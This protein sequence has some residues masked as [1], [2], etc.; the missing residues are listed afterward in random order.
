[1]RFSICLL[2]VAVSLG[3]ALECDA[4]A[5]EGERVEVYPI[6]VTLSSRRARTQFVVTGID[7]GGQMR[8]LTREAQFSVKD[9]QVATVRSA[10]AS[11]VHDGRTGIVVKVGEREVVVP[12][13]V[14]G[15]EKPDPVRFQAETLAVL[16]KQGCNA[17]SCHGSPEGKGGFSLSLFA[18][19]PQIDE[20]SLVRGGRNRRTLVVEPAESLLLRKPMLRVAHRGGKKLSKTDAAYGILLDWIAEGTHPDP[21]DAPKCTGVV[22]HPGPARILHLPDRTQQQLSVSAQFSD[23]SSR[24]VTAIATYD[25]SDREVLAV[26]ANGLAT[27]LKRGQSA[28]SVRYQHCLVSVHFTVIQDV[29]GFH[30][31]EPPQNNF[32]DKL[33]DDRLRLLQYT[34][35][36]T[37]DDGVFLRRVSLDLTG[38]LPTAAEAKS[39]LADGAV[40]KRAKLIDRLLDS[41]AHA[42]FW[43]HRTADLLR[44][45]PHT[46]KDGRAEKF[47]AWIVEAYEKNTPA[48]RFAADLLTAVGDGRTAAPANYYLGAPDRN[49]LAETTAQL[50]L[51]SRIGCAKCHNHPFENWTQ[52]DYF[53][54]GAVFARVRHENDVVKLAADGEVYHPTSGAKL[55][56]WGLDEKQSEPADRRAA[57]AAWLTQ[58]GNPFFAR[59]EANR[60]W[61]YLFGRGLVDPVDD[62]RSSNPPCN[63]PLLDALGLDFEEHGYDRKRL[64]RLIC[65]SRT[66]QRA[67]VTDAFNEGDE[68]L[69]SHARIRRLSAEQLQDA[70]GYVTQAL[71]SP[72]VVEAEI[73]RKRQELTAAT[74]E[75]K[76]DDKKVKSLRQAIERLELRTDWATQRL[77]PER[78]DFLKAFGQPERKTAC[79][80]E[81][82]DEPTVDQELQLLNGHRVTDALN[83]AV[84]RYA[85]LKDDALV[86]ELYLSAFARTP[87]AVER[88]TAVDY[89]TRGANR[90]EAVRDVVWAVLNTQEFL[91]QH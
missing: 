16:T 6:K 36:A 64:V 89:L 60:T 41:P 78:S 34:P 15:Q 54:I 72:D 68:R 42:R 53:R 21:A 80:C 27:G 19:A 12:V 90:E 32:I 23:G 77:V 3:M 9:P 88:K 85:A 84:R 20:E 75:A 52:T 14:S 11:P 17:G 62:F 58:R 38:L 86:D 45:N 56:A 79:A 55:R 22:V 61:S 24:D 18:Y 25:V 51:G 39:F 83:T 8:D 71:R 91:F 69:C 44:V 47:A 76:P 28:L 37:C 7:A 70:V 81:R 2:A 65:N 48:D 31:T 1:M 82:S 35:S 33:V 87:T 73:G 5:P 13:E 59:V 67:S 4:A 66:Y 43:A 57:F 74:A 26:D 49:D 40:D 10:V 46:L 30:W 63:P 50:F 29:A